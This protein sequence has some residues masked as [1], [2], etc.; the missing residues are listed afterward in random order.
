MVD[1]GQHQWH[2]WFKLIHIFCTKM[3]ISDYWGF[4]HF[5]NYCWWYVGVHWNSI[6]PT[7]A[8]LL[9]DLGM[10]LTGDACCG[11]H[12]GSWKLEVSSGTRHSATIRECGN[13]RNIT[14][15][16]IGKMSDGPLE[17]FFFKILKNLLCDLFNTCISCEKALDNRRYT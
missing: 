8:V 5:L 15:K 11:Q 9:D 12:V 10:V 6:I 2:E 14:L 13:Y 3:I 7:P 4:L 1:H 16:H 17:G